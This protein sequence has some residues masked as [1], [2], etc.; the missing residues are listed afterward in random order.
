MV[1]K[2][3]CLF[4]ICFESVW[5]LCCAMSCPLCCLL[6]WEKMF[7]NCC[8]SKSCR[9]WRYCSVQ[10]LSFD[11]TLPSLQIIFELSWLAREGI[12]ANLSDDS[13]DCSLESLPELAI[14]S[15]FSV[16]EI[17]LIY[18]FNLFEYL[19]IL[20]LLKFALLIRW[21]VMPLFCIF[22]SNSSQTATALI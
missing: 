17:W 7:L 20:R 5:A 1:L 9:L 8:T 22:V 18:W 13:S 15:R 12:V 6:R 19:L 10:K 11:I 14:I 3:A 2:W 16:L 4:M 21:V